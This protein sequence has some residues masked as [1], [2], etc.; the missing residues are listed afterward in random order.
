MGSLNRCSFIGNLGKDVD[1]RFTGSGKA[2]ANFSIACN[3]QWKGANGD[4]QEHVEWIRVTCW[5]RLA[6]NCGK[7]LA[8]GRQVYVEGSLRTRQYED[9]EGA[10]KFITELI[11]SKVVFLGGGEEKN[12]ARSERATAAPNGGGGA[13]VSRDSFADDGEIPF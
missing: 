1:V 4:K 6:E 13:G 8:K 7:Y 9:K 3:E 11:A 10:T 2:V 5:E 12:E